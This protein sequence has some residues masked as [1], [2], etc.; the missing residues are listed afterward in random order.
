[1]FHRQHQRQHLLNQLDKGSHWLIAS[2]LYK[3][4]LRLIECITLKVKDIALD[5][6]EIFIRNKTG[7]IGRKSTI[8]DKLYKPLEQ[9]INHTITNY[10][11]HLRYWFKD[12]YQAYSLNKYF[13]HAITEKD[14]LYIFPS[15]KKATGYS[16]QKISNIHIEPNV[17]Q[18]KVKEAAKKAHLSIQIGCHTL[19]HSYATQLLKEGYDPKH[20]QKNLG[21][22]DSST[23]QNYLN[24]IKS[25]KT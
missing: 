19:R 20:V 5:K 22:N 13:P 11:N 6:N 3:P 2:L 10:E 7:K 15:F 21:I 1:M 4:G 16:T 12:S 25:M 17:I 23:M 14:D 8:P 9:H 24:F 18:R